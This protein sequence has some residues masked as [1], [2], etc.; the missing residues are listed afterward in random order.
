MANEQ[1]KRK[2]RTGDG[3]EVHPCSGVVPILKEIATKQLA[4]I[5]TGFFISRYGLFATAA[6]VVQAL[7]DDNE[8][9]ISYVLHSPENQ[10]NVLAIQAGFEAFQGIND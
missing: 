1:P 10:E 3:S 9:G 6:H 5:G 8:L 2:A 4:V 7:V